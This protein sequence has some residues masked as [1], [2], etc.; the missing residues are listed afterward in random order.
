MAENQL[1]EQIE[2][3]EKIFGDENG[4]T[5]EMDVID[6]YAKKI[7]SQI[8]SNFKILP[9]QEGLSCTIRINL[10]RD[11]SVVGVEI[12]RSSGNSAFDRAAENS[13]FAVSPFPVPASDEVF[14]KMR[15]ITFV[16]S[17]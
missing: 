3:E 2:R 12:L 5:A 8:K 16:F 10:V 15:E 1:F 11:G 9:G 6:L 13:V 17:P 14:N 4:N 7:E